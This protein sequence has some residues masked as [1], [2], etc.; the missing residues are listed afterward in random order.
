MKLQNKPANVITLKK[1]MEQAEKE[2][3]ALGSFSPRY[4]PMIAAVLRAGQK[5]NSP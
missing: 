4:T 2:G 3:Y 1:G 5:A